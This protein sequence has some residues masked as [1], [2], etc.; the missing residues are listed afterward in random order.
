MV[1]KEGINSVLADVTDTLTIQARSERMARVK[2]KN[3]TP[4]LLV[5]SIVHG[6]GFR[7]RLHASELPGK[8]DIV[9]RKRFK[10]IFVHG[11]FWHRH[12]KRGCPLARLPKSRQEFWVSKL[13]GNRLRD[14][15][16]KRALRKLGWSVLE[17]WECE[18]KD[19]KALTARILYFLTDEVA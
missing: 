3:T 12:R 2:G 9:L 10:A 17:I 5:R 13:E 4:E 1:Y 11:C 7:F 6:L 14:L 19:R 18:L 15:R 16:N 8:P